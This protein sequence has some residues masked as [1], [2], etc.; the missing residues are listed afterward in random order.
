[1][2]VFLHNNQLTRPIP[3]RIS[4]LNFLFGLSNNNL[5]GEIPAALTEID[6]KLKSGKTAMNVFELPV[7]YRVY[8]SNTSCKVL[9]LK[10]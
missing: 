4:S 7:Y 6:A 8:H 2:I 3:D 5:T 9:F 10:C 1:V